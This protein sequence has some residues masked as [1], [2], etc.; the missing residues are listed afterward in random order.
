MQDIKIEYPLLKE[1]DLIRDREY[2]LQKL[3]ESEN[4]KS[5][6]LEESYE[7]NIKRLNELFKSYE[8]L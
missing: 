6:T 8:N 1:V 7:I 4:Q 5:Y 2:I 3:E